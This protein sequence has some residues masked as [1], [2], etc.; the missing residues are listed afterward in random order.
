MNSRKSMKL[1]IFI[2]LILLIV[3]VYFFVTIK[4]TQIICKKTYKFDK[5]ISVTEEINSRIDGKKIKKIEITKT[6]IIPNKD[7]KLIKELKDALE[8]TLGYLSDKVNYTILD[9]RIIVKISVNKNEIVLL[10]NIYFIN[11]NQTINVKINSN[12]KSSDVIPLTVGDNYTEGEF[13][14]YLK[15]MGYSCK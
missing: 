10:N 11:S 2:T 14:K 8:R 12:T 6:I 7:E 13:M 4:Q 5:N 3:I 1:P 9:D 15:S